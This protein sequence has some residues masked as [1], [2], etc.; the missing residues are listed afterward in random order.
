MSIAAVGNIASVDC[1]CNSKRMSN[2]VVRSKHV[3]EGRSAILIVDA[4]TCVMKFFFAM[5]R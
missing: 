1:G 2:V 5:D 3:G 4:P